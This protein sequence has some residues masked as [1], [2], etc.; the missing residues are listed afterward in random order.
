MAQTWGSISWTTGKLTND[1]VNVSL[2]Y[3]A[4]YIDSKYLAINFGEKSGLKKYIVP[5]KDAKEYDIYVVKE[6]GSGATKT[7]GAGFL[8]AVGL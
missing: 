3:W 1:K 5:D 8:L 7:L 4:K 2:G 6:T